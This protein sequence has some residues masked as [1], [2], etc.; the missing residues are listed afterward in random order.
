MAE[1][2]K[3]RLGAEHESAATPETAGPE[4]GPTSSR[5]VHHSANVP[6]GAFLC[7]AMD[8]NGVA[9][10]A[11]SDGDIVMKIIVSAVIALSVLAGIAAPASAFDA[12]GFYGQL[13]RESGGSSQ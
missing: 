8:D 5:A 11:Y 10:I 2:R 6:G 9:Q 4:A 12:K 3:T 13:E 7:T 1:T